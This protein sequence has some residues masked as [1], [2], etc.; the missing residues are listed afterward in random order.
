MKK[1]LLLCLVAG[2]TIFA[3]VLTY[4]NATS[5]TRALSNPHQECT[6]PSEAAYCI[7]PMIPVV[8]PSK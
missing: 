4:A 5:T 1:Y 3:S 6:P 8:P 7:V 2:S